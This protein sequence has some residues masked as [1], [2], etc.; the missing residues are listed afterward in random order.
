MRTSLYADDAVIFMSPKKYDMEMLSLILQNFGEVTG[1]VTN[2]HKSMVVPIRFSEINIADVL[3][4]FPAMCS[5]FPPLYIWGYHSRCTGFV[6]ETFNILW[7]RWKANYLWGKE[8]TLTPP[9]EWN[10]SNPSSH[11]KP[12]TL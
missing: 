5:S 7:I 9:V 6:V 12:S 8:S 4:G 1:L 10:W 11:P 2:V 3:H